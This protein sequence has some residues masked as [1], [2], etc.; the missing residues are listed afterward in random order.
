MPHFYAI[1]LYRLS[2]Y[3]AAGIPV[4]PVK[5]GG[6]V[7][8]IHILCY[9]IAFA[10]ACSSL[11]VFGYAGYAYLTAA[12]TTS[13]WWLIL[14]IRGFQATNDQLWAKGMF[15]FSLIVIMALSLMLSLES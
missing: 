7:T 8:K 9:I 1:A 10:I 6:H 13:L 4:L 12:L 11:L 2:E 15:R 3:T 14:A 5:R